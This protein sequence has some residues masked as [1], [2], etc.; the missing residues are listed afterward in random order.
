[1]NNAFFPQKPCPLLFA[2]PGSNLHPPCQ[3]CPLSCPTPDIPG[4]RSTPHRNVN[5]AESPQSSQRHQLH[6]TEV[7]KIQWTTSFFLYVMWANCS[8][9]MSTIIKPRLCML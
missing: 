9:D 7:F 6:L 2:T 5:K 4:T 3:V 1:M 8:T